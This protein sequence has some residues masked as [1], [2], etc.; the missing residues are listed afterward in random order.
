MSHSW[1]FGEEV[2]RLDDAC[3]ALTTAPGFLEA[4][5]CT[6]APIPFPFVG[7]GGRKSLL[8]TYYLKSPVQKAF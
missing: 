3:R 1:G 5:E 4:T 2:L 7:R 6:L 8:L